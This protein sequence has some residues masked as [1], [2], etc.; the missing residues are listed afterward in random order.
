MSFW[1][2]TKDVLSGRRPVG[3]VLGAAV[4]GYRTIRVAVMGSKASGKTVFAYNGFNGSNS[5]IG[6]GSNPG[7]HPD[8]T[9]AK[10]AGLYK[11]RRLTIFV[12]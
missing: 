11:S 9:F 5:D 1:S 10:N 4:K 6:I 2:S 12:K 7:V 8:W 3:A